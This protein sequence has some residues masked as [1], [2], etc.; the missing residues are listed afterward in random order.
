MWQGIRPVMSS[1]TVQRF[2]PEIEVRK[3]QPP[4]VFIDTFMW[5]SVLE[6]KNRVAEVLRRC[7]ED[8]KVTVAVTN[9]V[10]GELKQ[11]RMSEAV[12]N[13]CGTA[14]VTVPMG[15]VAA[16]QVIQALICYHEQRQTVTLSW[17]LA[18]S[19]VPVLDA[20]QSGMKELAGTLARELNAAARDRSLTKETVVSTLV[21]VEREIWKD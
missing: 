3:A 7:C 4:L 15:Q 1:S 13:L 16:N 10:L 2:Y 20:P 18:L 11:R 8:G 5:R 9:A 21:G 6:A 17:D 14:L 19:E 12:Q